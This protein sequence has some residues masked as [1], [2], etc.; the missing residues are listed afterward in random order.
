MPN[1]GVPRH[2]ILRP[3]DGADFI[4]HCDGGAVAV[5]QLVEW[6]ARRAAGTPLFRLSASEGASLAWFLRYWLGEQQLRP[7][8]NM[9]GAVDA[10]FDW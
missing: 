9:R 6:E 8:Y 5:Y 2:M 3:H 4:V 1:G 10:E 7:G